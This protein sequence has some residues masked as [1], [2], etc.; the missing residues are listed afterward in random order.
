MGAA[1]ERA[2]L[3][4]LRALARFVDAVLLRVRGGTLDAPPSRAK[5][6]ERAAW[7]TLE[8]HFRDA[9]ESAREPEVARRACAHLA[10][11]VRLQ[12]DARHAFAS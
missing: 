8:T 6:R 11:A 9:L 1:N 3:E 4:E 10:R 12:L 7:H 2:N 5:E